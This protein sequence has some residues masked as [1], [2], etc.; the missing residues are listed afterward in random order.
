MGPNRGCSE[1][2]RRNGVGHKSHFYVDDVWDKWTD[3]ARSVG[4]EG[5]GAP[6]PGIEESHRRTSRPVADADKGNGATGVAGVCTSA[7]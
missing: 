4:R 3:D 5:E 7:C 6:Q 1:D 2:A